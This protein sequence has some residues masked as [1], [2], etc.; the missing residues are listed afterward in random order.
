MQPR[1]PARLR[2]WSH[3]AEADPSGH[4]G[5][6]ASFAC[7]QCLWAPSAA[8]VSAGRLSAL[9]WRAGAFGTVFRARLDDVLPV[10][11]KMLEPGSL[12]Q[13]EVGA[14]MNEVGG[15]A[16]RAAQPVAVEGARALRARGLRMQDVG[17]R[18]G[19]SVGIRFPGVKVVPQA[20]AWSTCLLR[21]WQPWCWSC[22]A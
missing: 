2:S 18:V 20:A 7:L 5:F 22:G 4:A 8:C 6:A 15:Q 10:A 14:L 9:G 19:R 1:R 13:K 21:R 3:A 16:H 11:V 17:L 12:G